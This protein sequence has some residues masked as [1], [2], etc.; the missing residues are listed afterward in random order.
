MDIKWD[1]DGLWNWLDKVV[2]GPAKGCLSFSRESVSWELG[3][4]PLEVGMEHALENKPSCKHDKAL[5]INFMF[6][7]YCMGITNDYKMQF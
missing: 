4:R 1:W 2:H 3:A 5:S 7:I 6:F